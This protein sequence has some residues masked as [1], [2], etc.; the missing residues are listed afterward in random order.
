MQFMSIGFDV[1][2]WEIWKTLSSG[3]T[4]V[5]R[6]TDPYG[7]V[8]TVDM[9]MFTITALTQLGHPS[10]YP[11]LKCIATG[12]ESMPTSLKDLWSPYVRLVNCYGPSECSITTHY[13]IMSVD[14]P[15]MIGRPIDNVLSYVLDENQRLVPIGVVG[16]L[17]LGGVCVSQ[18]YI[19]LPEQT[20]QRFLPDPF[21]GESTTMFRTGDSA[22]LL[23]DGNLQIMGRLDTQVKVKGYRVELDEVAEAMMQD[24]RVIS[25]A[26]ILKNKTHLVGYFSP[27]DVPVNELR[28]LVS[29]LLPVYMVPDI[30]VGL[31]SLPESVNG[32]TDR[33]VLEDMDVVIE[34]EDLSSDTEILLARVWADVLDIEYESIGRTTSF[35]SLGGDSISA[36]RLVAKSK[37]VGLNL[38]SANVM[39]FP[40]LSEMAAISKVYKQQKDIEE[41]QL[42][43]P[44]P[45]TPIQH[46]NF[47]HPWKNANFWNLSFTIQP[48]EPL[49][50]SDLQEAVTKLVT[51]HDVLRTRF[52]YS[53]SS[54]WTQH[55]LEMDNFVFSKVERIDVSRFEELENAILARETSLNLVDGPVYRVTLFVVP[56]NTQYVHFTL[57]HTITDLVSWRILMD[58]LQTCLSKKPLMVKSTSFKEWSE[59]LTQQALHWD[60]TKWLEYMDEDTVAPDNASSF[61]NINTRG[62]LEAEVA[63]KLDAANVT[64]GTN[65]QEIAL[66]ALTGALGELRGGDCPLRLMM[67][68][69]GREPWTSDLDL[70]CTVGWFTC[71]FPTVFSS[72]SDISY[73]LCQVK[74]KLR[75]LPEKGLSYGAIKYLVPDSE[76]VQGI[77]NHKGHNLLFNYSGKFQEVGSNKSM[78]RMENNIHTRQKHID[79]IDYTPGSLNLGHDGSS[80]VLDLAIPEWMFSQ[81]EIESWSKLWVEW[82]HCIIDHCLDESTIGGRVLADV[83]LLGSSKVLRDVEEGLLETLNLRPLDIEDIYPVTGMQAGLL[84]A[85]MRNPSEYVLQSVFDIIGDFDFERLHSSWKKL[86]L[87]IQVLR[88]VFVSTSHGIYQA[89]TKDDFSEWQWLDETWSMD[90]LESRTKELMVNDR[91]RGFT[92]ESKSFQRFTGIR[93]SDGRTRV[94]WT[95]HHS[96]VDGWT[97][98]L[99][100]DRLLQIC[101]NKHERANFIQFKSYIQWLSNQSQDMGQLFW[102]KALAD[103][104]NASSLSLAKPH[105]LPSDAR[106]KYQ[107]V[108]T[109]LSLPDATNVC[110][111][112]GVTVSSV[113]RAGWAVLLKHYTRSDLVMFGSIASG[114][115]SN[116]DGVE[117]LVG[118]SINAI[119]ILSQTKSTST[120]QDA[121]E[122]MHA[123]S[124]ATVQHAHHSLLD[125]KQWSGMT[126]RKNFFDSIMGYQN[127]PVSELE[128]NTPRPFSLEFQVA[129]EFADSMI[130]VIAEPAGSDYSVTITYQ[131]SEVDRFV[132][133][134]MLERYTSVVKRMATVSNLSENIASLNRP[135][136]RE[137]GVIQSSTFANNVELPYDLLHHAFESRA[138]E[139]PDL[140]AVEYEESWLSY[141][142]LNSH[143]N[144][145]ASKLISIGAQTGRRV[146]VV[147]DRS[148][149]LIVGLLAV[150]KT[151]ASM[152]PIDAS[153]PANRILYMLE[154]SNAI[155]VVT[156]KEHKEKIEEMQLSV[157]VVYTSVKELDEN[158]VEL[159]TSMCHKATPNDEVYV[160]YTSG[161]TGKPK[162]VPVLHRSVVNAV[163]VTGS[164]VP[165]DVGDRVI[166]FMAIGF[167]VCQWEIWKALSNGA[168]LVF[169]GSD[170]YKTLQTV[171]VLLFTVSGVQ[172]LGDPMKYP[173]I[174]VITIGGESIPSTLKDLWSP[175]VRLINCYGPSECCIA[176]H[177]EVMSIDAPVSIG[178]PIDNV[179]SYV[180]DENQRVV[181][182][183]VVG[184]LYLGGICV[185]PGYIN[186]PD[187]TE[188]RFIP[189]PF[190]ADGGLMY[191]T[192]DSARVTPEGSIQI[193][194]R[195]DTQVK[196]KGYRVELDEVAEVITQHPLVKEAAAIVKDKVHLVG[197]F[198]PANVDIVELETFVAGMLPVYMV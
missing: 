61:S 95:Q 25:A 11:K 77:K 12:G 115:D 128:A 107:K 91:L 92:L 58:D 109:L 168:T 145:L 59:K 101:F 198:T 72:S 135:S 160:V 90:D 1:C 151:G 63:L 86:S 82:M 4:L 28:L 194:G 116:I 149:E 40:T 170:P 35:Y 117:R 17:Y 75:G 6:G 155:A 171:N 73:L 188:K 102:S 158:P 197:Y 97:L 193:L 183:G 172:K 180:L 138:L 70:S 100:R 93:V 124:A 161:S 139:F 106:I 96:L 157:P 78:F 60:P 66:A 129:E 47:L 76:H 147:M 9:S 195:L 69:H 81:A 19:N 141:S 16:E 186:L 174:K 53:A 167:D 163:F 62:V 113:F 127:F 7:T 114:R 57:H 120:I 144:T 46:F 150:L 23:P 192:G 56:E 176:T 131:T 182:V 132:V 136:Q 99:M 177:C 13:E 14:S 43:G 74:Q 122:D 184:E 22:R 153:F 31:H 5:L 10:N 119:P 178:R 112:L 50:F 44:V 36:I 142:Q 166:Q 20:E 45:L 134:T 125:I 51:H 21:A 67:E 103:V 83:P 29:D 37:H 126:A 143:A 15:V 181:P 39:K 34:V 175:H 38:T 64:Y 42:A 79:D 98:S 164:H 185:S 87:D 65:I 165:V 146:A 189:N 32:K 173:N 152:M 148:L 191:R 110:R 41:T 8:K 24:P 26:A 94:L 156:M 179:W 48:R 3:A 137:L 27:A 55:I 105:V 196:L 2:Q 118:V 68:G 190:V 71:M 89:V 80:L 162:G 169:R 49:D 133:E 187:Q 54:G 159:Q 30:W 88:T 108:E 84:S 111:H 85:M 104:N 130:S 154:D 123:Y 33:K 52:S 140:R 18:G 121:I